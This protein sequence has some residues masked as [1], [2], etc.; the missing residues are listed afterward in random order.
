VAYPTNLDNL[1]TSHVAREPVGSTNENLEAGAINA[2]EAKV[3]TGASTPATGQILTGTGTGASAWQAPPSAPFLWGPEFQT[4]TAGDYSSLLVPGTITIAE[5]RAVKSG[6][7]SVTVD[8]TRNGVSIFSTPLVLASGAAA[9]A[10][11]I[12]TTVTLNRDDQLVV[13]ISASSGSP[14]KVL[15]S[16]IGTRATTIP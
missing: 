14:S 9:S 10:T 7:T 4:P 11:L 15:T 8:V 16:L 1:P 12:T 13:T 6:G 2:L 5:F 3:G